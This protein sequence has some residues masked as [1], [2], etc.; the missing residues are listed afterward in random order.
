LNDDKVH[1]LFCE[2]LDQSAQSRVAFIG[3]R[4]DGQPEI[5]A[6]VLKLLESLND[7]GAFMD[8]PTEVDPP[9]AVARLSSVVMTEGPPWFTDEPIGPIPNGRP[10]CGRSVSS[11]DRVPSGQ[12]NP[13]T[14]ISSTT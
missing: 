3:D 7:A 11:F 8:S 13:T 6:A 12:W 2:A 1:E 5:K 14:A 4:C 9:A 10:N